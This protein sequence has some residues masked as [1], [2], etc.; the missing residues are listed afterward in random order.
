MPAA[1]RA[2]TNSAGCTRYFLIARAGGGEL[3]GVPKLGTSLSAG[4]AKG[5]K[6]APE[7]KCGAPENPRPSASLT[8][9]LI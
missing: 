4:S 1:G 8:S 5:V 6:N 9:T 2:K 7:S 3:D